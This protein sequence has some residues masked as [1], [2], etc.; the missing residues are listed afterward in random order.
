MAAWQP[1]KSCAI[2]LTSRNFRFILAGCYTHLSFT[3]CVYIFIT[4]TSQKNKEKFWLYLPSPHST[5]KKW[6]SIQFSFICSSSEFSFILSPS[7]SF[8]HD[9]IE[10][11]EI[12]IYSPTNTIFLGKY[13]HIMCKKACLKLFNIGGWNFFKLGFLV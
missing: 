13:F 5:Q 10:S 6:S 7:L 4:F 8:A 9:I 1:K 12:E 2:S 11:F 3:V